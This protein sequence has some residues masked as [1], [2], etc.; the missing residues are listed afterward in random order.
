MLHIVFH[1]LLP[2][3]LNP[4]PFKLLKE[5]SEVIPVQTKLHQSNTGSKRITL[6][7]FAAGAGLEMESF[8][9]KQQF[10]G[11]GWAG[12]VGDLGFGVGR[13]RRGCVMPPGSTVFCGNTGE[14]GPQLH[15]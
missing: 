13:A 7:V 4:E 8:A 15:L 5:A 1:C 11:V 3:W 9:L 6:M 10:V 14:A 2:C 12:T